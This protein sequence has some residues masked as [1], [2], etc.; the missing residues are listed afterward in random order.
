MGEVRTPDGVSLTSIQIHA[1]ATHIVNLLKPSRPVLVYLPRRPCVVIALEAAQLASCPWVA[2]EPDTFPRDR[3]DT[4]VNDVGSCVCITTIDLE[5]HIPKACSRLIFIEPDSGQVIRDCISHTMVEDPCLYP[6]IAYISYTSGSTGIPKGV[7][8]KQSSLDNVFN[9]FKVILDVVPKDIWLSITTISFDIS[10]LELLLPIRCGATTLLASKQ[11]VC[12]S[13]RLRNLISKQNVTILQATPATWGMLVHAGWKGDHNLKAICGGEA[14]P[15]SLLYLKHKVKKLVNA[16]GPTE[17][18][19]W[20][21]VYIVTNDVQGPVV[22]I[23]SPIANT[24][25]EVLSPDGMLV[26]EPGI[27]GELYITGTGVAAGYLK[28]EELTLKS[29]LPYNG[30]LIGKYRTGDWVEIN[31][32]GEYIFLY[33]VDSQIKI[34]GHRI[35]L[36]AIESTLSQHELV[37]SIIVRKTPEIHSKLPSLTAYVVSPYF[38]SS[39]QVTT[40]LKEFAKSHLPSWMVPTYWHILEYFP[41]KP[42]GKVDFVDLEATVSGSIHVPAP[43][44]SERSTTMRAF[45]QCI[46]YQVSGMNIDVDMDL[47]D[48]G[49][50]SI[51]ATYFLSILEDSIG[52]CISPGILYKYTTINK[53]CTYLESRGIVYEQDNL[54]ACMLTN[55]IPTRNVSEDPGLLACRSGNT[56]TLVELVSRG[57]DVNTVDRFGSPGLHWG[58]SAGHL[59]ICKLLVES[60]SAPASAIDTKSGRNALHWAARYGR[61]SVAEWLVN[62]HALKPTSITKDGTSP[63][64]LAAWGGSRE[65]CIWL[66]SMGA[67]LEY[68]N[69]WKCNCV[70]F[71]CLAGNIEVCKWLRSQGVDFSTVNNQGHNALHKAAYGGHQELCQWIQDVVGLDLSCEIEDSRGQTAIDLA[72]KAGH[73]TLVE[74]FR[75]KS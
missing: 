17:T 53:L 73:S 1:A 7:V 62:E 69:K 23:G 40:S 25:M 12:S 70:H 5:S 36:G 60:F 59:A 65:M 20:S 57:W 54:T 46:V 34:H 8:I 61:L 11:D 64:H 68:R 18:C 22:P 55:S 32:K 71:A 58:A 47:A 6:G 50:Q 42:S 4:I 38:P 63:L 2:V 66:V 29:F 37:G 13:I 9:S 72:R 56:S 26:S 74:W 28:R 67:N 30:D 39:H 35:E 24:Y 31:S 48:S 43:L 10:I 52:V 16:Y 45:L 51:N 27:A 19:I 41:L 14:F 3:L 44:L 75:T 21:S 49:V 33:R 15:N